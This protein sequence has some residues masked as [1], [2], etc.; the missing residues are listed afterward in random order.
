MVFKLNINKFMLEN[1]VLSIV[2]FG[3]YEENVINMC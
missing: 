2:V 3:N 1:E